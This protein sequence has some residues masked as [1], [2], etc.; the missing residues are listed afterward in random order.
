VAGRE[1]ATVADYFEYIREPAS[2]VPAADSEEFA[3]IRGLIQAAASAIEYLT[4]TARYATDDEG[5]PV[6]PAVDAAM[7]QAACAQVAWFE[8]QGGSEGAENIFQSGGLGSASFTLGYQ[9]GAGKTG[10]DAR[11][12]PVA[13]ELLFNAGL[14]PS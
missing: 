1:Y 6:A 2:A 11:Y 3:R 7:R 14:M 8:E 10:A 12:A 5:Y 4:M 9:G 13:V